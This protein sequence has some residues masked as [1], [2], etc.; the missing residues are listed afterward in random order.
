LPP[1]K[2][3]PCQFLF[4]QG[5]GEAAGYFFLLLLV[6]FL[7]A[8]FFALDAFLAIGIVFVLRLTGPAVWK[9]LRRLL[10]DAVNPEIVNG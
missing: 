10:H 5:Y 2:K 3:S 9:F 8:G 6:F 7:G 4:W 1:G